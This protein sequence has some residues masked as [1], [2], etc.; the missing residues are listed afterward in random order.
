M[1]L[2]ITTEHI[3]APPAAVWMFISDLQRVPEWVIGTQ[4][5]LWISTEEVGAGTEY[6]ELTQIGP[7]TSPTTWR[8][9]TFRAPHVQIHETR[10]AMVNATLTMTLE[11]ENGGT[12][13]IHHIE[14][15]LL[16]MVPPL[17]WLLGLIMHR[18]VGNDMRKTLWQAKQIVEQEYGARERTQAPPLQVDHVV[19]AS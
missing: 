18:H 4:K 8:I 1:P 11:A 15:R 19:A 9:T 3:A 10:S 13:F 17:G 5:M 6:R 16:P 14:A 12:R 2:L 7:T